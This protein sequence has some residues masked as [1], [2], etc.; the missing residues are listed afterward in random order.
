MFNA[1]YRVLKFQQ[2]KMSTIYMHC[3]NTTCPPGHHYNGFM[4]AGAFGNTHVG[5]YDADFQDFKECLSYD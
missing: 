1:T 2:I 5:F 4:A 3:L